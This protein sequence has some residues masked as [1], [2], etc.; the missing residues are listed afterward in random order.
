MTIA[1]ISQ[2][3]TELAEI[4]DRINIEL[5]APDNA[6]YEG[7]IRYTCLEKTVSD[8]NKAISS[9]VIALETRF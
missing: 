9:A 6:H 8:I 3:V 1:F 4:R 5:T 7:G 2:A